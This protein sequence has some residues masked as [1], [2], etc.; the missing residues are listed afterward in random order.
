M[1]IK[2]VVPIAFDVGFSFLKK[3][4]F[5][6]FSFGENIYYTNKSCSTMHKLHYESRKH[7]PLTKPN[8]N[9]YEAEQPYSIL[10]TAVWLAESWFSLKYKFSDWHFHIQNDCYKLQLCC[11][12]KNITF[13]ISAFGYFRIFPWMSEFLNSVTSV[14]LVRI[15]P[16][17]STS[18]YFNESWNVFCIYILDSTSAQQHN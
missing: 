4:M 17:W 12:P 11:F 8:K 2:S 10:S 14:R 16:L 5:C 15:G 9:Q 3:L 18:I 1:F 13:L 6:I 7:Q